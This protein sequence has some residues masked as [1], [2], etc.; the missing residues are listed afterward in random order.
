MSACLNFQII[1][2]GYLQDLYNDIQ[3]EQVQNFKSM[4]DAQ[5]LKYEQ[6]AVDQIIVTQNGLP[7]IVTSDGGGGSMSLLS[8]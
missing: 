3:L 5:S 1:S 8:L 4:Y 6:I 7:P 2:H